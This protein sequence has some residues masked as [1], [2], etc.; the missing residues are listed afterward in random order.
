MNIFTA[1]KRIKTEKDKHEAAGT[2]SPNHVLRRKGKKNKSKFYDFGQYG[3]ARVWARHETTKS[4]CWNHW[5]PSQD[6]LLGVYEIVNREEAE[7]PEG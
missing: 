4:W 2:V 3:L 6:D 1:I 7:N 5:T